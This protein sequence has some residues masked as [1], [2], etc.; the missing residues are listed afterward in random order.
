MSTTPPPIPPPIPTA[1]PA[2]VAPPPP[3]P[4]PLT[5]PP[6]KGFRLRWYTVLTAAA[7]IG[8][9]LLAVLIA[10]VP[11]EGTSD[12]GA[13]YAVMRILG[14]FLCPAIAALIVGAITFFA[15]GRSTRALNLAMTVT[16]ILLTFVGAI[17]LVMNL[18]RAATA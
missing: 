13:G 8:T 16:F 9:F 1:A 3:P 18:F 12:F 7:A 14:A 17:T 2:Q 4:P 11:M 15:S 6:A 5:P 10:P